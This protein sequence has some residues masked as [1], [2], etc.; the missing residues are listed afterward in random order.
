MEPGA[1]VDVVSD[2]SLHYGEL[3]FSEVYQIKDTTSPF[4]N[5]TC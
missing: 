2:T 1:I 3:E 4:R 5:S